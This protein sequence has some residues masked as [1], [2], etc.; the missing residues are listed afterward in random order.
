MFDYC[1][2]YFLGHCL[3]IH[4]TTTD[5]KTYQGINRVDLNAVILVDEE[6]I[7]RDKKLAEN[8]LKSPKTGNMIAI[9]I[10]DNAYVYRKKGED[11]EGVKEKVL[12]QYK[13][14]IL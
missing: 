12:E 10:S 4:F 1:R 8:V 13:F 2:N 14:S 5:M 3:Y 6:S 11:I 9:Q 7:K